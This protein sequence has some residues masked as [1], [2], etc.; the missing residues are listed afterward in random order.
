MAAIVVLPP[1]GVNFALIR[2]APDVPARNG[3]VLVTASW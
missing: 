3:S 1:S 2:S